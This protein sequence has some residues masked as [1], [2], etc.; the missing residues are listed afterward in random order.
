MGKLLSRDEILSAQGFRTDEVEVDEWQAGGV[1]LVRELS[2]PEMLKIGFRM[3][4]GTGKDG[5]VEVNLA[6]LGENIPVMVSWCV[7][8]GDG[9]SILSLDDINHFSV[10]S[11]DPLNRIVAKIM[12]LSDM[13]PDEDEKQ[14]DNESK[15]AKNV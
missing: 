4:E 2:A 10:K 7:V 9:V 1:V 8:D 14:R 5:K 6:E 3:T 13:T 11:V 15:P 12:E